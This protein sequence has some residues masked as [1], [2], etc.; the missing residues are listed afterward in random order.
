MRVCA[1]QYL[2]YVDFIDE[3]G[4]AASQCQLAQPVSNALE[5]RDL[6]IVYA[7]FSQSKPGLQDL[8][9]QFAYWTLNTR[10]LLYQPVEYLYACTVVS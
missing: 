10:H 6:L 8:V 1:H 7:F 3:N 9:G 5:V 2:P 4:H